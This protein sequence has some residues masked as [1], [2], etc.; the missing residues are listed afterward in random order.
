M[1]R[2]A[3]GLLVVSLVGCTETVDS[4]DVRTGGVYAELQAVSDGSGTVVKAKLKVGGD[5]SNTFL[6]LN[7][8]DQLTAKVEDEKKE[9]TGD[10]QTYSAS[11]E[12]DSGGTEIEVAFL[13]G[14]E[15]VDAPSSTVS[16]PEP[17]TIGGVKSGAKI[18]RTDAVVITWDP[19][20]TDDKM[21]WTLD[22]NCVDLEFDNDEADDGE[23]TLPAGRIEASFEDDETKSCKV[24]L[25][26]D[27]VRS[28]HVDKNFGEGGEFL[29]IQ[30]RS[31]S[32]VSAP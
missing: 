15:D 25:T 18:S 4:S 21:K 8:A 24:T 23:L 26:M 19:A 9:L 7:G 27:R 5:D 6:D 13:R 22:G 16:L 17:F 2:L 29:G 10:D 28:G 12:A 31:I 32:F 20:D 14:E 1:Q 30:R 11:F 3:L